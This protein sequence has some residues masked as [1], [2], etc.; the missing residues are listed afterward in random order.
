MCFLMPTPFAKILNRFSPGSY[1]LLTR[2]GLNPFLCIF[3]D[4][5]GVF[6]DRLLEKSL[7][8]ILVVYFHK[9]TH[10]ADKY[11]FHY[12][13]TAKRCGLDSCKTKLVLTI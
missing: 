13:K 12:D 2:Y 8:E 4:S 1:V 3:C 7:L 11:C 9:L 6:R 5:S 10:A